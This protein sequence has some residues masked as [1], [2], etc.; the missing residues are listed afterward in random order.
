MWTALKT[1][2]SAFL[3]SLFQ[4]LREGMKDKRDE[5]AHRDTGSLDAQVRTGKALS[6]IADDQQKTNSVRND[7]DA[8]ADRLL[9]EAGRP[10]DGGSKAD[11]PRND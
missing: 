7:P 9:G 8:I 2:I 11:K 5:Q 1:F 6:E 3:T 4:A 10:A